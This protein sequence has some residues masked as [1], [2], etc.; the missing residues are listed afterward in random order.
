M[1]ERGLCEHVVFVFTLLF[2]LLCPS[3]RFTQQLRTALSPSTWSSQ[4]PRVVAV[5][6]GCFKSF[7]TLMEV[8]LHLFLLFAY[9]VMEVFD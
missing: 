6:M 2:V 8:I 3:P 1:G 4:V 5:V 9:P 7:E